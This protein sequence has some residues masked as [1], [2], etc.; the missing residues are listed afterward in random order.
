MSCKTL[1]IV[2]LLDPRFPGGTSAAVA[3]EIRIFSSFSRL[4][5]V[6]YRSGLFK[7][8]KINPVL[9][10]ALLET[11][12]PIT[13]NPSVVSA[14]IVAVHNPIFLRN[15]R[16]FPIRIFCNLLTVVAHENF[17]RP[18]GTLAFDVG[19]CLNL[20]SRATTARFK[21]IAPVSQWNRHTTETW[22][23][24]TQEKWQLT[25]ENWTN[26]C[27]F[28]LRAP[29]GSPRDKRGRHSR[30]GIEKF[31]ALEALKT[32]FPVHAEKV[33]ILGA[34]HLL[35]MDTP[36]HWELIK[37][38]TEE[39]DRFLSSIDFMVY[40]TNPTLR[41]SFGR[42][43]AEALAA[44]KVVITD[45]ETART[46]GSG[47]ISA[48]PDEVDNIILRLC[49]DPAAY[50]AQVE[51]GQKTLLDFGQDAWTARIHRIFDIL[52]TPQ[53]PLETLHDFL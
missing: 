18:T 49:A 27:D 37:F 13:W 26:I 22:I 1:N 6:A 15:D 50:R 25:P 12:T 3:R 47:V 42:V 30:P 29:S 24:Q 16:A 39:V 35:T 4:R 7:G 9:E 19:H 44:G 8:E 40:Y 5:V 10:E 23:A 28:D 33:R 20:I 2:L 41:E 31:P 14:D 38:G 53:G 51:R 45:P 34:D 52:A 21:Q 11:G 48:Q 46:F 43:I 17:L 32:I 36:R